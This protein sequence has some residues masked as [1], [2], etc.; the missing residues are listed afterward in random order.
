MAENSVVFMQDLKEANEGADQRW[1][2]RQFHTKRTAV[3]KALDDM[4]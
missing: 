1:V 4:K 3:E 2:L